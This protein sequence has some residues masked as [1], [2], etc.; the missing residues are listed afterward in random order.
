MLR[1]TAAPRRRHDVLACRQI[2]DAR[3][4]AIEPC[5]SSSAALLSGQQCDAEV[6]SA[7]RFCAVRLS[8]GVQW[9]SPAPFNLVMGFADPTLT[10]DQLSATGLKRTASAARWRAMCSRLPEIRP[11]N[12]G[13]GRLHFRARDGADQGSA[14]RV[15]QAL[16]AH[17]I[18]ARFIQIVPDRSD[19][20]SRR[21]NDGGA[22]ISLTGG[23]IYF[24]P[25]YGV[26]SIL[27]VAT[28]RCG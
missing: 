19:Q 12:E 13:S 22:T 8:T 18:H 3:M 5:L 15:R 28:T 20:R 17:V 7:R 9:T 26:E 4:V 6:A 14:R 25:E 27:A 10:V 1:K 16:A 24:T 11:R 23:V 21:R 2:A